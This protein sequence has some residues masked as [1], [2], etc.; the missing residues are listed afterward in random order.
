M[1]K[2]LP[3][4][5]IGAAT[6][7]FAQVEITQADF[8][9]IGESITFG[10]DEDVS[11]LTIDLG[12][13]GG[14][15]TFDFTMFETDGLTDVGFYDP[16][17]VIGGSDFPTADLAVDQIGGIF[18]FAEVGVGA[19]DI[20]GLGGDFAEQLGSPIPIEVSLEAQD[21]WTLFEFPPSRS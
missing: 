16:T 3:L 8:P 19:V 14:G 21:P 4:L 11:N 12:G 9:V 1:K 15:Q 10:D 5:F 20:I 6:T 17:T 18:A 13:T 7:A 2:L